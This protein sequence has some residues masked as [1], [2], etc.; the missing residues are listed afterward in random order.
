MEAATVTRDLFRN[1]SGGWQGVVTIEPGGTHKAISVAPGHEVWLTED[2]QVLTANAP[3]TEGDNPLTN[4]SLTCVTEAAEVKNRRPLR[5]ATAE[6]P[7]EQ[8]VEPPAPEEETGAPPQTPGEPNE[9][10]RAPHEEVGTPE[11]TAQPSAPP[12]EPEP[13]QDPSAM[14]EETPLRPATTD[15]DPTRPQ[16]AKADLPRPVARRG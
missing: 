10:Q 16:P 14:R 8:P 3:R 4:G 1:D 2:E 11:A 5:P 9:G 15:D 12:L 6:T 7:E 13:P